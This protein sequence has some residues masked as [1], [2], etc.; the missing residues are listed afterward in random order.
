MKVLLKDLHSPDVFDLENYAPDCQDNFGFLLQAMFGPEG[1]DGEESFDIIICTPKW[2]E[3]SIVDPVYSG[4]HHLIVCSFNLEAIRKY[5]IDY[6]N[7]CEA[8]TW[9]EAASRLAR[10]GKWEFEDYID[11]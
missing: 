7:E 4:R 6:A 1:E 11:K 8:P 3:S 9:E 10:I 5:L 2:L